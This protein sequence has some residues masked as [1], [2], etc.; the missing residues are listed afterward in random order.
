[1]LQCCGAVHTAPATAPMQGSPQ[2]SCRL[3]LKASSLWGAGHIMVDAPLPSSITPRPKLRPAHHITVTAAS[4]PGAA[5]QRPAS[6]K[7]ADVQRAAQLKEQLTELAGS[8]NGTDRDE[9]QRRDIAAVIEKLEALNPAEQPVAVDLAGTAWR[10][11][12]SS[13]MAASAGKFGPFVGRVWQVRSSA[14][15]WQLNVM[16]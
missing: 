9:A 6:L 2:R 1:M 12:Y 14:C 13:S 5:Q 10:L 16:A 15:P 4:A 11:V 7:A 3:T 8:R